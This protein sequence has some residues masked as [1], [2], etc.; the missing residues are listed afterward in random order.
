[1]TAD[2]QLAEIK[3]RRSAVTPGRWS[4]MPAVP[5]TDP[6]WNARAAFI[7]HAPG[8]IDW[9]VAEVERLRG[10]L[11][12][13]EWASTRWTGERCCP[14]CG[15]LPEHGHADCRLAAEL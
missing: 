14:S 1:V 15:E 4:E 5:S 11:A 12:S 10:L 2:R 6:V 8:D 9:L 3:A 7:H 13:L